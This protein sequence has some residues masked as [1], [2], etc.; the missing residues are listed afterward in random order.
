MHAPVHR[1]LVVAVTAT[2]AAAVL[3]SWLTPVALTPAPGF[4]DLLV[5]L[6]AAVAAAATGWLWLV[7][8]AV[9][10]EA[11]GGGAWRA[12]GVP[13]PVRRALLTACGVAVVAGLAA[14]AGAATGGQGPPET[15]ASVVA[16]AIAGLPLPDRVLGRAHGPAHGPAH[17]DVVTVHAG[18]SLWSIADERLGGGARWPELYALNRAVVGADPDLIQP[19]QRLRLPADTQ[20]L[21]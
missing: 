3:L 8:A 10:V 14:P 6:C 16:T 9:L 15:A 1:C 18:D 2:A 12:R 7:T 20:E 13:G 17:Q 4:D 11:L 19:A 5:R 21:R